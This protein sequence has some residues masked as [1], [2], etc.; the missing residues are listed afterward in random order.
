MAIP[1]V[2]LRIPHEGGTAEIA[3]FGTLLAMCGFGFAALSSPGLVE[4]SY[5]VEQYHKHNTGYFAKTGP[6]G[7]LFAINNVVF[8]SL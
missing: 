8:V 5:V 3:K 7:Q 2:L 6:W 1:L 4:S